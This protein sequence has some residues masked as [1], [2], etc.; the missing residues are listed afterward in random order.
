MKPNTSRIFECLLGCL[1]PERLLL[2]QTLRY[3]QRYRSTQPTNLFTSYKLLD[4]IELDTGIVLSCPCR[5]RDD[6][7][8]LYLLH[9]ERY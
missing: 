9:R 7:G 1:F 5:L 3:H 2:K 4:R 8:R 6:L